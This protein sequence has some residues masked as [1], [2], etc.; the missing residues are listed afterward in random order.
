MGD[1]ARSRASLLIN[2]FVA[3]TFS[4]FSVIFLAVICAGRAALFA[5]VKVTWKHSSVVEQLI[6]AQ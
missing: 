4:A 2:V 6:A 5:T 1:G 3:Q